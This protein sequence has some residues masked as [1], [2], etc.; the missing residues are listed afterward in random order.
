V[1]QL[2]LSKSD[3]PRTG[4]G[5]SLNQPHPHSTKNS[6][7][8]TNHFFNVKGGDK[9]NVALGGISE[10]PSSSRVSNLFDGN[11]PKGAESL[12]VQGGKLGA[13]NKDTF[14]N[15]IQAFNSSAST[16]NSNI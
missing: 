15:Y 7:N 11:N 5:A 14:K 9:L 10:Y 3:S 12:G 6:S 16:L 1:A 8:S 2:H 13:Y 4:P